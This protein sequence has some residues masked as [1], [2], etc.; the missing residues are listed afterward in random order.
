[1]GSG[2]ARIT[3][4]L[5]GT[6]MKWTFSVCVLLLA[7]TGC[8]AAKQV[9]QQSQYVPVPAV[10]GQWTIAATVGGSTS[11]IQANLVLVPST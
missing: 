9:S 11:T 7:L 1:M 8:N 5:E 4:F 10:T 2:Y 6:A 3:S